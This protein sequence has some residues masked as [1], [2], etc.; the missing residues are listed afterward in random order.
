M[1]GPKVINLE[2][3]R[4]RQQRECLALL[5]GMTDW[6]AEWRRA[7]EEAGRFTDELAGEIA[8]WS[9]RMDALREGAQW[10]PLLAELTMRRNFFRAGLTEA[11]EEA[12]R[13]RAQRRE[14]RRRLELAAGML[15]R[16]HQAAG[17]S[18][19]DL[20]AFLSAVDP[21]DREAPDAGLDRIEAML[22][23]ALWNTPVT[24]AGRAP[25]ASAEQ[26]Q[27]AHALREDPSAG[28]PR[29][30]ATW[31]AAHLDEDNPG[32]RQTAHDRLAR[33]LAE[34]ELRAPPALS[35]P[36]LAKAR[37]IAREASGERRDL[38]TDSLLL[39]ADELC[40]A[41]RERETIERQLRE[42]L[43]AFAAFT[44]TEAN[45]WRER[46]TA[47]LE[48][49]AS[50]AVREL[51]QAA[52]TWR[53]AEAVREDAALRRETLL[54]SLAALGYEVREG[55]ITAWAEEGRV[56]VR[57]PDDPNYGIELAS[58]PASA[59]SSVQ[60]RVV[61]FD[62][63]QRTAESTQRDREIESTWCNDFQRLRDLLT[64]EG[65]APTLVQAMPVGAVPLKVVPALAPS[66]ARDL[67]TRPA[68][69]EQAQ[70]RQRQEDR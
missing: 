13:E 7:L 18:A 23:A 20:E 8:A 40:R 60:A 70:M 65:F 34:L 36:L 57:K 1:S 50:A 16:E 67:R 29:T 4:R 42:E 2:A 19:P 3:V 27:L 30:V 56:V 21:A 22:Q 46:L 38:L 55:M 14:R 12:L 39:E 66:R 48:N 31:L 35:A 58:P 41:R 25:A 15:L 11:G 44:S 28:A 53:L 68:P 54:R 47:A 62:A 61:A 37:S 10:A 45:A 59:G 26:E 51:I 33:A 9:A 49:P 17:R 6:I 43:D 64:A 32:A 52:E 63:G 69:P 5:R 24:E